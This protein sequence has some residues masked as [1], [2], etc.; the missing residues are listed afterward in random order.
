MLAE[1][2]RQA[3]GIEQHC[4]DLKEAQD[5]EAQVL[6]ELTE[7]KCQVCSASH[8][9]VVRI[10]PQT[11]LSSGDESTAGRFAIKDSSTTVACKQSWATF[12]C[13]GLCLPQSTAATTYT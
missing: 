13:Y 9:H 12:A 8:L 5:K 7:K 1:R 11:I 3:G 4:T 2:E 10:E 6:A